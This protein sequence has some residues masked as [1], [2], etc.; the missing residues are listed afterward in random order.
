M[1]PVSPRGGSPVLRMTRWMTRENASELGPM[2][3]NVPASGDSHGCRT[4]SP[5]YSRANVR[6]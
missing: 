4:S 2:L 6:S 5:R 3:R 1:A